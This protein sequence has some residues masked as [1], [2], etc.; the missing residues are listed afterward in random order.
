MMEFW[1]E[2]TVFV[3]V[4]AADEIEE[5]RDLWSKLRLDAE[6]RIL[7]RRLESIPNVRDFGIDRCGMLLFDTI[8]GRVGCMPKSGCL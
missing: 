4:V 6:R 2:S 8:E 7:D 1:K 5:L 3:L